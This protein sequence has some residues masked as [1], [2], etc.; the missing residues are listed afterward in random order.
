[1]GPRR[2]GEAENIPFSSTSGGGVAC[3]GREAHDSRARVPASGEDNSFSLG[4][5][6]IKRVFLQPGGTQMQFCASMCVEP[7]HGLGSIKG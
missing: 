3:S 5:K 2:T 4:L 1:M 6:W 7:R